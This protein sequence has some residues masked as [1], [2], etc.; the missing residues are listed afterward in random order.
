MRPRFGLAF[1]AIPGN[2]ALR[3]HDDLGS[4][5]RGFPQTSADG[6]KVGR[7]IGDLAIHLN[8]G[9]YLKGG[10]VWKQPDLAA[11]F[12]RLQK[13]GPREFYEGETARKIADGIQRGAARVMIG[14]ETRLA[15]LAV[16][17]FPTRFHDLFE[18]ARSRWK[19]AS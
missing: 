14:A 19:G 15:D 3:K 9:E 7:V 12:A 5:S 2:D 18:L 11:T 4:L 17:L 10:D 8:G 1:V 16:R 6:G 13:D